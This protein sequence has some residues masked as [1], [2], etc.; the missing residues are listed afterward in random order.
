MPG[1]VGRVWG[2]LSA[3]AHN[4]SHQRHETKQAPRR[5]CRVTAG[6]EL[7][8]NIDTPSSSLG[9]HKLGESTSYFG[10][11]IL[12]RSESRCVGFVLVRLIMGVKGHGSEGIGMICFRVS[13]LRQAG[14]EWHLIFIQENGSHK[15]NQGCEIIKSAITAYWTTG[16]GLVS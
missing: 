13:D 1:P 15:T 10:F 16:G 3:Q 2:L 6:E 8:T 7:L 11:L 4:I 14:S 9:P 12:R 5:L